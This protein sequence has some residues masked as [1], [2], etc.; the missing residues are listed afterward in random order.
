MVMRVI[1]GIDV[2]VFTEHQL[3]SRHIHE[4]DA[5]MFYR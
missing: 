2:S 3:N 5:D 1:V 4:L